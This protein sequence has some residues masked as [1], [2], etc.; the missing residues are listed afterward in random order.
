[1]PP[2]SLQSLHFLPGDIPNASLLSSVD[3]PANR[4]PGTG[5]V[6]A[7][8]SSVASGGMSSQGIKLVSSLYGST[9]VSICSCLNPG[10]SCGIV[11]VTSCEAVS[12]SNSSVVSYKSVP[13]KYFCRCMASSA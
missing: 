9:P 6:A 1:M 8:A 3:I 13:A 12:F 7:G 11:S 2:N 4:S 10:G 5:P